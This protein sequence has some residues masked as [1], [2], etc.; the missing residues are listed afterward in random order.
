M[1]DQSTSS[2]SNRFPRPLVLGILGLAVGPVSFLLALLIFQL[3]KVTALGALVLFL[4]PVA[5]FLLA[6]GAWISGS[7]ALRRAPESE[8]N[9]KVRSHLK[10]GR[11]LGVV[12]SVIF[13]PAY[14]LFFSYMSRSN[15]PP[16]YNVESDLQNIAASA[17]TYRITRD[18]TGRI[19]GSYAG[20]RLSKYLEWNE[21]GIYTITNVSDD[22]LTVVGVLRRDTLSTLTAHIGPTGRIH[23]LER[24]GVFEEMEREVKRW[25]ERKNE[26]R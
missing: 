15:A 2:P 13:P 1:S 11:A 23:W 20:Y 24:K 4:G 19:P 6:V 25:V 18:S 26:E 5:G 10:I 22:S 21:N 8:E 17:Y 9:A 16:E 3:T 14:L 7:R 12:G